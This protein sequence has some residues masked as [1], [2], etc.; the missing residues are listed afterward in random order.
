MYL[1]WLPGNVDSSCGYL[2][3]AVSDRLAIKKSVPTR[4]ADES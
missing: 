2:K 4:C 1:F 3:V